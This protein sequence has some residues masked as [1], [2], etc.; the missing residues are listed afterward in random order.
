[1]KHSTSTLETHGQISSTF[2][3]K[4]ANLRTG[5]CASAITALAVLSGLSL[6]IAQLQASDHI[7]APTL[8]HDKA[9]DLGDTYA[10][11]DPND[12]SQMILMMSM[13]PF[14]IS[15]EIIGQAIFDDNI[16]YRFEI[17]N[18][19]DA[20]PDNFIDV[21]FSRG[22]G[23]LEPQTAFIRLPGSQRRFSAPVTIALQG[24]ASPTP[25]ITTDAATG[26]R[27]FAGAVDD[28]FFLDNTAA[29]RFVLSSIT[30][31]G[32]PD[33]SVFRDRAGADGIG[34]DTYAGFNTLIIVMSVPVA[35]LRGSA[36]E[37]GV[38]SVTMRKRFQEIFENGEVF[39][40]GGPLMTID[41][42]GT[43]LI[44]NG[45]IPADRKNEYNAASTEDDANGRFTADI[46]QSLQN[47][48]TRPAFIN[49]I[50]DAA[51]RNGDILR[52]GLNVPNVGPGG[53]TNP[54][55]GFGNG[56]GRR[57]QDDVG[58]GIF[59]LINNGVPLGD[60]VDANE[61]P[62]RNVFPFIAPAIQPNPLG[63]NNPDDRTRL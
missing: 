61:A 53:G 43:P 18:T 15:S 54:G 49:Q 7:D 29:N 14:L 62:F 39:P 6:P 38:N 12:N 42:D 34:R 55:G 13:N 22:L 19:G 32:N 33:R 1:M 4:L 26:V 24:N 63:I 47:F 40:S 27:F 51:V 5:M 35:R 52:V 30:S 21:S 16:R 2:T 50:L 45:L 8:A 44:N 17:E 36:D 31:P 20:R 3:R 59:T 25:V 46:I 41:R 57:L 23:R 48:G 10:F 56:G 11:L 37:I 60:F 28:P 9:S 58:D